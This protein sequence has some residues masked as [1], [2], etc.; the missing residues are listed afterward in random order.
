[1]ADKKFTY[2]NRDLSWLSFNHRVLLEA[3]DET[4]P[5]YSR[6]QFLSIFSS[7]LDEFFRVRMPSI[8]AFT[9]LD[10]KKKALREEYPKDLVRSVKEMVQLQ[11]EDFGRI[12]TKGILPALKDNNIHLYY[13]DAIDPA[14]KETIR[15]YF[16]S[17]VLSFLQPI[18]LKTENQANV[19]LR[20]ITCI[21]LFIWNPSLNR[22]H[23]YMH[24]SIFHRT[25]CQDFLICQKSAIR[26]IFFS[27]MM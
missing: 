8:Y 23:R 16:L 1:M 12:L 14:H 9:S 5:L 26:A 20:T 19:F 15:E 27:W 4:V 10:N 11:L 13:G 25:S 6:I 22:A 24:C 21:L 18:I 2:L 7:N 3:D 17:R